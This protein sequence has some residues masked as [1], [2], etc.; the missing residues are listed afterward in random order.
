MGNISMMQSKLTGGIQP[1]WIS[2]LSICVWS[3]VNGSK[4]SVISSSGNS[5]NT[6][7]LQLFWTLNIWGEYLSTYRKHS[8]RAR[9]SE[10]IRNSFGGDSCLHCK[11]I[12]RKS[13]W[14]RVSEGR[15]W[16]CGLH[17]EHCSER[18]KSEHQASKEQQLMESTNDDWRWEFSK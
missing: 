16:K 7:V 4:S 15:H 12:H 2:N 10:C 6:K 18:V 17:T 8:R 3:F 5:Q 13:E 1:S 9:I 11:C 14:K